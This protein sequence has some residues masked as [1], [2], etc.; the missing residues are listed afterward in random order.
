[1]NRVVLIMC[2]FRYNIMV[3]RAEKGYN[4]EGGGSHLVVDCD[5]RYSVSLAHSHLRGSGTSFGDHK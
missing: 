3:L 2:A 1:M 5:H 4:S